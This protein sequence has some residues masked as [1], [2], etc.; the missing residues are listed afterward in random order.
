MVGYFFRLLLPKRRFGHYGP[1]GLVHTLNTGNGA[2]H[3]LVEHVVGTLQRLLRDDTSLLQQVR[4]D[5]GTSQFAGRS[6]M[7][8]DELT[9]FVRKKPTQQTN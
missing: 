9:L 2:G 4:L 8:T 5:I 7:D 1:C 6:E 3:D